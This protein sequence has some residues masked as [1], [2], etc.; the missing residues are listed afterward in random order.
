LTVGG[1]CFWSPTSSS[2]CACCFVLV[3]VRVCV[4][5]CG[6]CVLYLCFQRSKGSTPVFC[7]GGDGE[8]RTRPAMA[9]M[10]AGSVACVASSTTASEKAFAASRGSPFVWVCV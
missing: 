7:P 8:P 3:L 6:G 9:T 5:V 10:L 2:A 4:S 1:S